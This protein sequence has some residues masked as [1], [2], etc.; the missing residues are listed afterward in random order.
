MD[1]DHIYRMG[2]DVWSDDLS[3]E[4]YLNECRNSEKYQLGRWYCLE[5]SNSP[6]SSLIIYK[7]CFKLQNKFAGFGSISTAPQH[8]CKGY[9]SKLIN[10]CVQ[11]LSLEG[12]SGIYLHCE[13]DSSIYKR[14]GFHY[15]SSSEKTHLMFLKI[16]DEQHESNPTYF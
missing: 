8:R 2:M 12:C 10:E 15:V 3:E 1:M 6:A 11:I 9:A 13:T 7:N 14:L 4:Q 16:D 5:S